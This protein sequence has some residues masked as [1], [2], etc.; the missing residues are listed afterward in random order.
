MPQIPTVVSG[1]VSTDMVLPVK[2]VFP[3]RD[4]I[5]LVDG[6][7]AWFEWITRQFKGGEE[8]VTNM[9]YNFMEQRLYPMIMTVTGAAIAGATTIPCDHPEYAHTRQLL[10]NTS[11]GE[12]YKMNEATGGTGTAGSVTVVNLVGTGG[13][14]TAC[15]AGQVLQILGMTQY[16]GGPIPASFSAQPNQRITYLYQHDRTRSNTDIQKGTKEYGMK[17]LMIDRIECWVSES[18]ATS[19]N[20]YVGQQSKET[21]SGTGSKN[22]YT[23]S[24][25]MEQISS[26]V[27]DFNAVPGTLTLASVGEMMRRTMMHEATSPEKV[28]V[29]GQ[30]AIAA[31]SAMPV[32]AIRTS[33]NETEWGKNLKTLV[34]PHGNLTVGYDLMLSQDYGMADKFFILDAKHISRLHFID[35]VTRMLLNVQLSTDIHNQIDV[36]TGTDGILVGIEELHAQVINIH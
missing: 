30:N 21:V 16:E 33:V 28:G 19:M 17:Q 10:Y 13:I 2:I 15:A 20:L 26:N 34:T 3:M 12:I 22:T 36:I 8:S 24:G 5:P 32:N 1:I 6:Q 31:I 29:C 18:R 25:I 9:E 4:K 23:M 27:I 11:T 35:E 7:R 14:T